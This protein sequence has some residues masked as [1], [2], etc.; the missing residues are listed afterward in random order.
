MKVRIG[1]YINWWGPYQI[2][3]LLEHIGVSKDRCYSLGGWLA[4]TPLNTVCEWVH[5]KR[6]RKVKVHID[7][8]DVWSMDSTLAPIILPMLKMLKEK[9]HGTPISM[10]AYEYSSE[11]N[12]TQVA[13]DFYAES[14]D[15]CSDLGQKQWD[16]IMDKMIFAFES[17]NN[18]WEE[19]FWKQKPELDLD[20]RPEDEGKIIVPLRWKVEGN[21]DW[22][23][24]RMYAERIQEGLD[25]FGKHFQ[26]LWD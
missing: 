18:D 7:N 5:D 13:F 1:P 24:R 26:S 9:K 23:G 10:P 21:C 3:G 17:F 2:A 12:G 14:D 4:E 15:L 8:Y 20:K 16:E 6:E 25:L 11:L 19:Q 22:E